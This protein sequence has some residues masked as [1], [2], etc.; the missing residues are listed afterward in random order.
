ML[1]TVASPVS[2]EEILITTEVVGPLSRTM[3]K[4][5]VVPDSSTLVDPLLSAIVNP[6]TSLSVVVTQTV[7]SGTQSKASSELPSSILTV[8]VEV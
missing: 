1:V 2:L 6:A 7:R 8:I 3:V 4:V 5:S